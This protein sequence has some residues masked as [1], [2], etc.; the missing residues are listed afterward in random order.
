MRHILRQLADLT[1]RTE[2]R[3]LEGQQLGQIGRVLEWLQ[4]VASDR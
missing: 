3:T 4:L 2:V 1:M